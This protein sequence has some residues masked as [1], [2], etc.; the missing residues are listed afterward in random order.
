MMVNIDYFYDGAEITTRHKLLSLIVNLMIPASIKSKIN[1]VL[2]LLY[3][4]TVRE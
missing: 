2:T 1:G 3:I 4:L